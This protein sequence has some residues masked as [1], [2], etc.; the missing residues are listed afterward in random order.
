MRPR[1][2]MGTEG[3]RKSCFFCENGITSI[4]YKDEKQLA[5]FLSERAKIVPRRTS[6]TCSKHQRQLSA[7]IKRARYLALVPYVGELE[8]RW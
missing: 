6:G 5:R 1:P 4:D 2:I 7:A 3:R 8:K